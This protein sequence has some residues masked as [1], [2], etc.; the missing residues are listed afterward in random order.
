MKKIKDV[1][2]ESLEDVPTKQVE[3]PVLKLV[4]EEF[5]G[6]NYS[7]NYNQDKRTF[8]IDVK[9]S[10]ENTKKL[11][12]QLKG[13]IDESLF[14]FLSMSSFLYNTDGSSEY[15]RSKPT[16]TTSF[17]VTSTKTDKIDKIKVEFLDSVKEM[18]NTSPKEHLKTPKK[19][20]LLYGVILGGA[21][22]G[23]AV[24]FAVP[25]IAAAG[26]G[27]YKVA[28]D[29][30]QDIS[31]VVEN[32]KN[33]AGIIPD[34]K[35]VRELASTI[36]T[37]AGQV[38]TMLEGAASEVE[39]LAAASQAVSGY[40]DSIGTSLDSAYTSLEGI[41][42]TAGQILDETTGDIA[43]IRGYLDDAVTNINTVITGLNSTLDDVNQII[44][45][46]DAR[47]TA[48]NQKISDLSG[49]NGGNVYNWSD[50]STKT[51]ISADYDSDGVPDVQWD[52]SANGGAGGY[53]YDTDSGNPAIVY[54]QAVQNGATNYESK[55]I[56]A[57]FEANANSYQA[58]QADKSAFESIKTSATSIHTNLSNYVTDL[59]NSKSEIQNVT[60]TGGDLDDLKGKIQSM[61]DNANSAKGYLDTAKVELNSI[62]TELNKIDVANNNLDTYL[63]GDGVTP[64]A[65]EQVQGIQNNA[66]SAYT[67]LDG[68]DTVAAGEALNSQEAPSKGILGTLSEI[69]KVALYIPGVAS[70]VA[71]ASYIFGLR[72]RSTVRRQL[73]KS[74]GEFSQ[75]QNPIAQVA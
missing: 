43:V 75:Y 47:V 3:E 50:G 8:S 39:V 2:N 60:K 49:P 30:Y 48:L 21:L 14:P 55:N 74:L 24:N 58:Y 71:A 44:T 16:V 11:K 28:S 64:G 57:M 32:L 17:E 35:G 51:Q 23:T 13:A 54:H 26:V 62:Y 7:L 72:K 37:E 46:A 6:V 70:A 66:N 68:V 9:G 27:A 40:A 19:D 15:G 10:T 45:D 65:I 33:A 63:N 4:N 1:S 59:E 61:S 53:I 56:A 29:L 36:G 52:P 42:T 67:Q 73:R 38:Y 69:P 20:L 18:A 31:P 41:K 5:D 22:V 25:V 12:R 34:L